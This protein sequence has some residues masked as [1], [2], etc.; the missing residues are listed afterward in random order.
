MLT[1]EETIAAIA[2]AY[3]EGGIGIIR[4][5]GPDTLP[6]L[7]RIFV[8][9][10][11]GIA[12][13]KM[14]YGHI[15]DPETGSII[16]EVLCVY[17]KEPHTYTKED[18]AEINCHGSM[19]SLRKTL[20]L[21]LKSGARLAEP[22]EFTKRAFLNGRLD[23]SQAE[24]VIDL[25]KA[26][27]D[28]SFD[29][30]MDQL[31]GGLSAEIKK[32]RAKLMDL[33]V[34]I[35]VNIDYPDEDIEELTYTQ[36]EED[37]LGISDM[38]EQLLCSADSGRMIRDG[39]NVSIIGKPNVGKSSLMNQL[40]RETRAIVTEIPG[41]TRDTIEEFVSIKNIPIRLTDTAGIRE[42]EDTIEKIGIEKSKQSFNEADLIIFVMDSSR[43]I[44]Q[45]DRTIMEYIGDR[46]VIVLIN[47]IDLGRTW[48]QEEITRSL[49][50]SVIL[51]T[52][53]LEKTGIDKIEEQIL[54]LVY[55]GTVKQNDSLLVTSV[56][57][58]EL[59]DRAKGFLTDALAMTRAKEAM[60][61]IEVDINSAFESL[62]EITGETVSDDII[63]QV[64]SRFCLGK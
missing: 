41:T 27:T 29:V 60:D 61:F 36:M 8:P 3:G 13:R 10:T 53:M 48:K 47:K 33:L 42:T 11:K 37:I 62:G 55:S 49:P 34:N 21:V 24:A 63:N 52:S 59:L 25:I 4:I 57:H 6:I 19:V 14:T 50:N 58:K 28:K 39:L 15:E 54:N 1:M 40:L 45:E 20:E 18:V 26:K 16:D 2:T 7:N 56:R 12:N 43:D 5:S 51:E 17:M 44:S 22:G 32:I 23:L 38:V 35:T 30:A 46:R 31:S 9:K 64:F